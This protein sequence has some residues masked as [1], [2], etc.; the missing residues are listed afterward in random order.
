MAWLQTPSSFH[1]P[2]GLPPHGAVAANEQALTA[3][4]GRASRVAVKAPPGP[5][6]SCCPDPPPQEATM[7]IEQINTVLLMCVIPFLLFVSDTIKRL[8]LRAALSKT[9]HLITK[10]F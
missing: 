3:D 10:I 6:A 9:Y 5:D 1:V 4:G 7:N 8:V 2:T